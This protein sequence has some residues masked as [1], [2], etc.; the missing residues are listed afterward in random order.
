MM[1]NGGRHS[2]P[3]EMWNG[4]EIIRTCVQA[5]KGGYRTDVRMYE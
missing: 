4:N 2:L 1:L 5:Y 3:S